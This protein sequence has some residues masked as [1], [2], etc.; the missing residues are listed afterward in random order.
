[1]FTIEIKFGA[2]VFDKKKITELLTTFRF[3][4]I[5]VLLTETTDQ[6]MLILFI[7]FLMLTFNCSRFIFTF[8][9]CC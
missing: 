2:S 5:N 4:L 7:Q 8:L 1:M 6:I 9:Q 3:H